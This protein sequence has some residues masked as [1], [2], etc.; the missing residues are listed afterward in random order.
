MQLD[1]GR[2][3]KF[4]RLSSI[5]IEIEPL[6][7]NNGYKFTWKS[8]TTRQVKIDSWKIVNL[9]NISLLSGLINGQKKIFSCYVFK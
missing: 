5:L 4:V 2:I 9:D 7:K 8:F 1:G 3:A 6:A